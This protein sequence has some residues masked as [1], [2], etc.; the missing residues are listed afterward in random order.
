MGCCR[1]DIGSTTPSQ[2]AQ[3]P[4]KPPTRGELPAHFASFVGGQGELIARPKKTPG[5]WLDTG[6][7]T[8]P[9]H[10]GHEQAR[11]HVSGLQ[12]RVEHGQLKQGGFNCLN[13]V[14]QSRGK[15][16]EP[17]G[18]QVDGTRR[19]RLVRPRPAGSSGR[20]SPPAG[21]R[22]GSRRPTGRASVASRRPRTEC[23]RS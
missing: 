11:L 9:C 5:S 21:S 1:P 23:F 4:G 2:A 18:V 20:R 22:P 14:R 12:A 6:G 13:G 3:P 19:A 7:P 10:V 8:C 16:N 17:A 15:V